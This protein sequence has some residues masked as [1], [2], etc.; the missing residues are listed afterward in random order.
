M[1]TATNARQAINLARTVVD[2]NLAK[3][4]GV[5][6]VLSSVTGTATNRK[7]NADRTAAD[8]HP[9]I[10]YVVA[11]NKSDKCNEREFYNV[12]HDSGKLNCISYII[13]AMYSLVYMLDPLL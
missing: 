11:Y 2:D 4:E 12:L 13:F 10:A 6:F 1:S 7:R 8:I 9:G 5:H 3:I